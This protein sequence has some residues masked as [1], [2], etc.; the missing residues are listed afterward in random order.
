MT[1]AGFAVDLGGT[2]TAAARIAGGR[3]VER[4]QAPTD[5]G[6]GLDAQIEAVA[7]LLARL[8]FR[9]G[10]ALG[11]AVAGRIDAAGGWH[12]VNAATLSAIDGVPLLDR[13]RDRF[14]GAIALCNDA[15]AAARGEARLGAGRGAAHFAYLTVSTG[16]GGG[17]VLDGRLLASGDGLAGHVGFV[18]SRWGDAPCGSGRRGTVESVASGRAIARAAGLA[19]ARAAF[20]AATPEARAAIDRSARAIAGLCADLRAI[21]GL[22]RIAIGGSVGLAPGYLPQ[23][24]G[25][26]ATEPALFRTPLVAA[27]LGQDSALLGALPD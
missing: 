4:L 22:D 26:L 11:V 23:V 6:A 16:V 9:T 7:A 8:G 10:A 18:S 17:V 15:A 21:F 14:G 12:A 1:A 19:D 5:G 2:K 27:A 13:L 25:H 20:A 3:I 24:I